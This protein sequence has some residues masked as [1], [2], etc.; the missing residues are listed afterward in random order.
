MN[1]TEK[2][3]RDADQETDS[4]LENKLVV[5]RGRGWRGRRGDGDEGGHIP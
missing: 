5:A 1:K 4:T 2:R 3:A